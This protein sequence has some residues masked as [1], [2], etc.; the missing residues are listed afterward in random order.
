MVEAT[1][2][3]DF[4]VSISGA[5]GLLLVSWRTPSLVGEL[6]FLC[7]FPLSRL[8]KNSLEEA[9]A[10]LDLGLEGP[11]TSSSQFCGNGRK[12]MK[13]HKRAGGDRW[14]LGSLVEMSLLLI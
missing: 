4:C 9:L 6:C 8:I 10:M 14:C 12:Y 13:Q 5:V 7:F 1:L 2:A 11:N 3:S